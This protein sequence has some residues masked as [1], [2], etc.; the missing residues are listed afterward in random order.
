MATHT[1]I[2]ITDKQS[3]TSQVVIHRLV[4]YMEPTI[5]GFTCII[6]DLCTLFPVVNKDDCHLGQ[7]FKSNRYQGFS[8]VA[9][10]G[11]ISNDVLSNL[12]PD[13]HIRPEIDY[14]W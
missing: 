8:I 1:F 2:Y 12:H 4:G 14:Y 7:I 3:A 13:V 9:W 11:E 10:N 5:P 6:N